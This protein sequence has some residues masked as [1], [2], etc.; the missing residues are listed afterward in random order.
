MIND[1][2]NTQS[3]SQ[4]KLV[5]SKNN[6]NN[7]NNN[8]IQN[9]NSE[10]ITD[11]LNINQNNK[12]NLF[13]TNEEKAK[14]YPKDKIKDLISDS[15]NSNEVFTKI[16]PNKKI[17]KKRKI[18]KRKSKINNIETI[19]EKEDDKN[20]SNKISNTTNESKT[21]DEIEEMD[22]EEAI[23]Y[24]KRSYIKMNWSSL[25]DSQ[26]ILDTFFSD[27]NLNLFIIKLS[28]FVS[29]FEI[30]FFLNALFY[31]DEYI[32]DAYHNNGVLDFVSGLPKSIYSFLATLLLSNLL[33]MLSNSKSELMKLMQENYKNKEY[34][35][36]INAKLKKLKIKLI[37][38]FRIIFL[39]LCFCFLCCL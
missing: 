19:G 5:I 16:K 4:S 37:I 1:L 20:K 3:L 10:N 9:D 29:I 34:L 13:S 6:L 38:Y 12:N 33:K 26:I 28:F 30:N 22:Y 21:E 24:D 25:V 27:S 2:T 36:L 11:I 17:I 18:K 31:T 8:L 7:N 15:K 14:N 39:V 35:E 32:S 23:I